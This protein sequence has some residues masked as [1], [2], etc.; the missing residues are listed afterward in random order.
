MK[1]ISIGVQVLITNEAELDFSNMPNLEK[2]S[3]GK[4][5]LMK[6][7][8]F[9]ISNNSNLKVID[10][11][12]GEDDDSGVCCNAKAVTLKSYLLLF[13]LYLYLPSLTEFHTG[14]YSFFNTEQFIL[15]GSIFILS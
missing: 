11:Q 4:A 6:L 13:Y 15:S 5:S 8:S 2:I 10:I 7:K 12:E 3:I 1:E 14:G 9:K